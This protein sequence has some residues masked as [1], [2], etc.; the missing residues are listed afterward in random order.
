MNKIFSHNIFS[1]T[2]IIHF[3][4][5]DSELFE[6]LVLQC[7]FVLRNVYYGVHFSVLR[8]MFYSFNKVCKLKNKTTNH[9]LIGTQP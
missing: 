1:N 2:E 9:L 6:V 7:L 5:A 4:I 3:L 8:F